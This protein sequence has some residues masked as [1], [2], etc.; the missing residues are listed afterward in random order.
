MTYEQVKQP[1]EVVVVFKQRKPEPFIIKWGKRYIR[2]QKIHLVHSERIGRD[3]VYYFSVSDNA[4][5][6]RLSFSTETLHWHMDEV[7]VLS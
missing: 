6:Y 1:V 4:N 2:I 5:A 3:K 7:R